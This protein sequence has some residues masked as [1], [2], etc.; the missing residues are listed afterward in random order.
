LAE[1]VVAVP[2]YELFHMRTGLPHVRTRAELSRRFLIPED[3]IVV[4]TGVDRDAKLEAWWAIPDREVLMATL[5]A[6]GVTLVTGPNF[7]LFTD[8]PRPDNLH[9]IK[10]IALSWAEL[11]AG[12]VSAALHVNARTDYDYTR[13]TDFIR[14]RT[15]VSFVAFEFG[16]GAGYQDRIEWHVDRLCRLAA[17]VERPLSLIVR[18]GTTALARLRANFA[19]VILIETDAFSRTLKRRQAEITPSGRLRWRKVTTARGEPL[20]VLLAH[21]VAERKR[22]LAGPLPDRKP[23]LAR[24]TPKRPTKHADGETRQFTLV[25]ELEISLQSRTVSSNL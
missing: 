1:K 4:V 14:S 17:N 13:W 25:P 19:E 6:L 12:G 2:L 24:A 5:R 8:T 16:T 20:D 9:S 11:M 10:R 23:R 22:Y 15:E 7:S 21:N 18:G 3:A